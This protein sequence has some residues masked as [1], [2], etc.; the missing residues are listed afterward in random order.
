VFGRFRR[1]NLDV[2][3]SIYI[4]D[5]LVSIYIYN[6]QAYSRKDDLGMVSSG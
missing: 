3:V 5:V 6:E 1:R 4:L 2:L